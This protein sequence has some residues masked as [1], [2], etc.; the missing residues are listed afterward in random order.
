[1]GVGVGMTC[2]VES[3]SDFRVDVGTDVGVPVGEE[4][5]V[6]GAQEGLECDGGRV[7]V[8]VHGIGVVIICV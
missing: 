1:M 3:E 5:G 4:G 6:G 8:Y 7:G 2:E